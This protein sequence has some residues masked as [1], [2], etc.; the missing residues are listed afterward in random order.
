MDDLITWLRARLDED[1]Q[2]ARAASQVYA[3]SEGA[4]PPESGVH[5]TWVNGDWHQPVVP[6]PVVDEFL[7]GREGWSVNLATVE[8]W[9]SR[10]SAHSDPRMMRRAYAGTIE[11]MDP[12]AAGHIVRWDPARVLAEI[13]AKRRV[14]ENQ[15]RHAPGQS[16]YGAATF[17]VRCLALPYADRPGYREEWRP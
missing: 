1:E 14:V 13:D 12:S 4:V 9:P 3:Y 7:G 5:W 17:A 16:G 8:R 15:Q 6:D 2:W 11:E 10:I